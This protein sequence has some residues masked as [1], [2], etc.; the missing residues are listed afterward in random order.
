MSRCALVGGARSAHDTAQNPFPKPEVV[1]WRAA[2]LFARGGKDT[3]S[4]RTAADATAA[5]RDVA[6]LTAEHAIAAGDG[7]EVPVGAVQGPAA[8]AT[9][10][11]AA[12]VR[13]ADIAV[14]TRRGI[15]LVNAS[16]RTTAIVRAGVPVVAV[17]GSTTA[18]DT[19]SAPI[20]HGARIAVVAERSTGHVDASD[21]AAGVVRAR[22]AVVAAR[23]H[24]GPGT[25]HLGI[26]TERLSNARWAVAARR[27][28]RARARRTS[29]RRASSILTARQRIAAS[30]G[31]RRAARVVARVDALT[32]SA[33]VDSA[34]YSVVAA[35]RDTDTLA[36]TARVIYRAGV[37]V[38]TGR[39][40]RLVRAASER[41]AGIGSARIPVVAGVRHRRSALARHADLA[42]RAC[43]SV[44]ARELI[45]RRMDAP[46][47]AAE[48]SRAGVAVDAP[49]DD[50]LA[51]TARLPCLAQRSAN[52]EVPLAASGL[53]SAGRAVELGAH[54]VLAAVD[55]VARAADIRSAPARV[56]FVC[57]ASDRA[58]VDR[59]L[60]VVGAART[61]PRR[62]D[63]THAPL[64][65]V[66]VDPV[67]AVRI[68]D[69][70]SG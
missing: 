35:Q 43:V 58:A 55:E 39:G 12:I 59:A 67:V 66:A 15:R 11:A 40:D 31:R 10:S 61:H 2:P 45:G 37:G 60:E 36:G 29:R 34:L 25:A 30:A 8:L 14:V 48:V 33:A 18:A 27:L 19:A 47:Q 49:S 50:A 57:A 46:A 41:V 5:A 70:G 23:R 54:G 9:T 69:T 3:S 44:V 21:S 4:R 13:C 52:A 65:T 56:R 68:V 17:S 6:I 28:A 63:P 20:S 51:T 62:A 42:A 22:V 1:R 32:R 38:I 53:A 7:A 64:D 16:A 26:G 24:A